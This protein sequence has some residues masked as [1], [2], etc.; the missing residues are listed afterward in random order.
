M[1]NQLD[2]CTDGSHNHDY[3]QVPPTSSHHCCCWN[4]WSCCC[5]LLVQLQRVRVAQY[6]M[7]FASCCAC[8]STMH[9]PLFVSNRSTE[10]AADANTLGS[11]GQDTSIASAANTAAEDAQLQAHFEEMQSIC[12][13]TRIPTMVPLLMQHIERAADVDAIIRLLQYV[14]RGT[15][16]NRGWFCVGRF[17]CQDAR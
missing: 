12:S 13:S 17:A 5:I 2:C 3:T 8:W 7:S 1:C 16:M 11:S 4:C 6:C 9:I 10:P 14:G 15:I